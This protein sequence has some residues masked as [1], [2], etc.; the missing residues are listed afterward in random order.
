MG[1][2]TGWT[3]QNANDTGV[4]KSEGNIA[5]V[6]VDGTYLFNT[7]SGAGE[8]CSPLKQTITHLKSGYYKLSALV[9]SFA[10]NSVYL[11]ANDQYKGVATPEGE[12][13]F[14]E[15]SVNF[16]VEDGVAD[17]ATV[18]SYNG[19]FNYP[20]GAFFKSDN[21]R[22]TYLGSLA[23]GRVE[24][25]LADA[26]ERANSLTAE[27]KA[28][29]LAAVAKYEN[30]EVDGD[31]IEEKQAIYTALKEATLSQRVANAEMTWAI[32][33]HSF[34]T[35]DLSGWTVPAQRDTRVDHQSS[36]IYANNADGLYLFNQWNDLVDS[37]D[38]KPIQQ[39]ITGLPNGTYRLTASVTSYAGKKVY[40]FGNGTAGEG[41]V[42]TA[43]SEMVETSVEFQVTDGTATIGAVGALDG[44]FNEE[45]GCFYK[46][47]N[48]RLTF[49]NNDVILNETDKEMKFIDGDWCTSVTLNRN[50]KANTWS[51]FVVPFNMEIP[52][53][54]E[55]KELTSAVMK[56]DVISMTFGNA[57]TIVAGTPYM[58]R[59]EEE[60]SGTTVGNTTLT[61][62]LT[63]VNGSGLVTFKG[64]YISGNVPE[65][66]FFMNKNNFYQAVDNTNTLK[67]FRGYFEVTASA[68]ANKLAFVIDGEETAING[69]E[70]DSDATIVAIYSLDGRRIESMQRGVNIVKLSDGKTKKVIVK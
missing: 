14:V 29:F 40:V 17:I 13:V 64:N 50:I 31:G 48:F 8:E 45:G 11:V 35:S 5:T 6:G 20:K 21:Y 44:E 61:D 63:D 28:Q 55:V 2:L 10:A 16:L 25:A 41:A 58:V 67:A 23:Q 34:E 59:A 9:T 26:K 36:N 43:E 66:M 19:K 32:R 46:V 1:D 51:T 22:L 4:K 69:V 49:V 53:G 12:G 39:T 38:N 33:N 18:G 70:A 27:A 52:A 47:D 57:N 3:V 54:W 56:D 65:G 60:W 7:W 30:M 68:G 24:I 62:A 15:H 42:A 37:N